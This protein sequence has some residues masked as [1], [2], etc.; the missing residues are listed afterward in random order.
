MAKKKEAVT[1]LSDVLAAY[2]ERYGDNAINKGNEIDNPERISMGSLELDYATGG[3]MPIGRKARFWGSKSSGKSMIAWNV[4]A[5]AQAKGMTCAYYNLEKQYHKDFVQARGVNVDELEIVQGT[6]IEQLCTFF[7][8][9]LPYIDVH[10]FDSCSVGNSQ[11]ELNAD[12]EEYR[13][14]SKAA[15]W[16]DG[17]ERS[18]EYFDDSRN[19][20]IYIDHERKAGGAITGKMTGP[21]SYAPGGTFLEHHPDL[22]IK[23]TAGKWLYSKNGYLTDDDKTTVKDAVDNVSGQKEPSG[24]EIKARV[25]KSRVCR[26]FRTATMWLDYDNMKFDHEY[27]IIK[28]GKYYEL[29][30][31]GPWHSVEGVE[32]KMQEPTLRQYLRDNPDFVDKIT[33]RYMQD[34]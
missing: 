28:A 3:G 15:A 24:R 26:P 31:G 32:K 20:Q 8:N 14:M 19:V 16:Q 9:T 10:V 25:E 17:F 1:E 13:P 5:N 7:M 6:N 4:I 29:I 11:K 33:E 18:M 22:T 30:S 21:S 23:F 2:K 27:E 34:A 12:L